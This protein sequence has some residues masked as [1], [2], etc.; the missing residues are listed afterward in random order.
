MNQNGSPGGDR[1]TSIALEGDDVVL[2][3]PPVTADVN[4]D[5]ISVS[6]YEIWRSL[7]PYCAP[8]AADC[9]VPLAETAL[10]SF[11]DTA[12]ALTETP[13]YYLVTAVSAD[14]LASDASNE[15][16]KFGFTLVS[17]AAATNAWRNHAR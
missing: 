3:W 10:L 6:H 13:Y 15:V 9:P 1:S 17:D 7:T 2:S 5:P 8:G 14:G 4:G 12:V 11:T 16:G